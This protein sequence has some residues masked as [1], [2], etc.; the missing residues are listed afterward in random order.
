MPTD[1]EILE[2]FDPSTRRV[3][4]QLKERSPERYQER[5]DA[6]RAS[7][8]PAAPA[9]A[10]QAPPAPPTPPSAPQTPSTVSV[11]EVA[12]TPVDVAVAPTEADVASP[13]LTSGPSASVGGPD[14]AEREKNIREAAEAAVEYATKAP[15]ADV[16]FLGAGASE[17]GKFQDQWLID[18]DK[19]RRSL[20]L[21]K[22]EAWRKDYE[23]EKGKPASP[24]EQLKAIEE[25]DAEVAKDLESWTNRLRGQGMGTMDIDPR[26]DLAEIR[27]SAAE[28]FLGR[29]TAPLEAMWRG[30]SID[31]AEGVTAPGEKL[32]EHI[33]YNEGWSNAGWTEWGEG[34][35]RQSLGTLVSTALVASG[36]EDLSTEVYGATPLAAITLGGKLGAAALGVGDR[37]SAI[38]EWGSD[39]HIS[40]L[41][42]GHD[43]F[44]SMDMGLNL[45]IPRDGATDQFLSTV[46][47]AMGLDLRASDIINFGYNLA[48]ALADVDLFTAA[49]AATGG[50]SYVAGKAGKLA[51][52][53]AKA[54]KLGDT[55]IEVLDPDL[56]RLYRASSAENVLNSAISAAQEAKKAG[57][58]SDDMI[59][60]AND[61]LYAA[62][63]AEEIS[64]AKANAIFG[65]VVSRMDAELMQSKAPEA[66]VRDA[67]TRGKA[68]LDRLDDLYGMARSEEVLADEAYRSG[69]SLDLVKQSYNNAR[70]S[71]QE[72][73]QVLAAHAAWEEAVTK[74]KEGRPRMRL[75]YARKQ[76]LATL[77][78]AQAKL[79]ALRSADEATAALSRATAE[80]HR[81]RGHIKTVEGALSK[82]AIT[83][84]NQ[85]TLRDMA[86]NHVTHIKYLALADE[87]QKGIDS[88]EAVQRG[89][90]STKRAAGK[91]L[92][93]D[94]AAAQRAADAVEAKTADIIKL[95][96]DLLDMRSDAT[97]DIGEAVADK[98][99]ELAK[100]WDEWQDAVQDAA[101]YGLEKRLQ[102]L[103]AAKGQ[104]LADAGVIASEQKRLLGVAKKSKNLRRTAEQV[105]QR[106]QREVARIS[107]LIN[108][109]ADKRMSRNRALTE[110]RFMQAMTELRDQFGRIATGTSSLEDA[111]A[112]TLER[113]FLENRAVFE[114]GLLA[115]AKDKAGS[116]YNTIIEPWRNRHNFTHNK[117]VSDMLNDMRGMHARATEELI[118]VVQVMGDGNAGRAMETYLTSTEPLPLPGGG[119]TLYNTTGREA[120]IEGVAR[121]LSPWEEAQD[122]LLSQ[123]AQLEAA[124]K[125]TDKDMA[126]LDR[127]PKFVSALAM[128]FVGPR[129][130]VTARQSVG[131]L[132]K[133]ASYA[134]RESKG[135]I[136]KF[137]KLHQ[138]STTAVL[139]TAGVSAR[140]LESV[141]GIGAWDILT[142]AVIGASTMDR[143]AQRITEYTMKQIGNS[144]GMDMDAVG[145][146]LSNM[147]TNPG[148]VGPGFEDA[149]KIFEIMGMRPDILRHYNALSETTKTGIEAISNGRGYNV[150]IPR[151]IM[152]AI[153]DAAGNIVKSTDYF[154]QQDAALDLIAVRRWMRNVSRL[155]SSHLVYG[156][157]AVK[158]QAFTNISV[159][160]T[161]QAWAYEGAGTALGAQARSLS[162]TPAVSARL[163]QYL[164]A[165]MDFLPGNIGRALDARRAKMAQ[166]LGKPISEVRPSPFVAENPYVS[167]I[168]DPLLLPNDAIVRQ[169][170]PVKRTPALTAGQLRKIIVEQGVA[171]T[172]ITKSSLRQVIMQKQ[173]VK[174][175]AWNR[176]A[177]AMEYLNVPRK[178]WIE[179]ADTFEQRQRVAL[180]LELFVNK[181]M[182]PELAAKKTKASYYDWNSP[183]SYV[184]DEY[185]SQFFMFW[186]YHRRSFDQAGQVLASQLGFGDYAGE[187]AFRANTFLSAATGGTPA[188]QARIRDAM[189]FERA[190]KTWLRSD[191]SEDSEEER[192]SRVYPGWAEGKGSKTFLN[193]EKLSE[194]F[195][196]KY[197]DYTGNDVTHIAYT[198]PGHPVLEKLVTLGTLLRAVAAAPF[199]DERGPGVG[200]A[201]ANVAFEFGGSFTKPM[202]QAWAYEAGLAR[203]PRYYGEHDWQVRRAG[204]K[205]MI[206]AI[207]SVWHR[208][209]G[210][211]LSGVNIDDKTGIVKL[212][213]GARRAYNLAA[214]ITKD[215]ATYLE[216]YQQQKMMDQGTARSIL[217]TLNQFFG[218]YRGYLNNPEVSL[219]FDERELGNLL[220]EQKRLTKGR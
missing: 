197:K 205:Q 103:R 130:V 32:P 25:I 191:D 11:P 163:G 158:P 47:A 139:G 93:V 198:A 192:L 62:V 14:N 44:S 13:S 45:G 112:I 208:L 177:K 211:D 175:S 200:E 30:A 18:V 22:I 115:T 151:Q 188:A 169:A 125:G 141:G 107:N 19:K 88:I 2:S 49:G 193:Q 155:I 154:V 186:A 89:M 96:N 143:S 27:E 85:L 17:S 129:D 105:S 220:D 152:K 29:A 90:S 37:R 102:S 71:V 176:V 109:P 95:R 60:A 6:K 87:L 83:P 201:L 46:P 170:D 132:I 12:T 80:T 213:P 38:L 212:T 156:L 218:T 160:N 146:A 16:G 53:V 172:F 147:A 140:G 127:A 149:L 214:P 113:M 145:K 182:D 131:R 70:K 4:L 5:L 48:L 59:R 185:I 34:T 173:G 28:S 134:L 111:Q 171:S 56:A 101:K 68:D 51:A 120:L 69:A 66:L 50:T 123:F 73:E 84:R 142:K 57:G 159:G 92:F 157:I 35:L 79:I 219:E 203:R 98:Q 43:Q 133:S 116:V 108:A 168:M 209:A 124:A 42:K 99:K 165:S 86:S 174:G 21:A 8:S 41:A 76:A 52:P 97:G 178:T 20:R 194:D 190:M 199:G 217:F 204:D 40:L 137:M 164:P 77:P 39:E 189:Q 180:F 78:E 72:N 196:K 195:A 75:D 91:G 63:D 119:V 148:N 82:R 179:M 94:P 100:A 150:F 216:Y 110:K 118:G 206:T 61:A 121:T 162:P 183:M 136:N 153:E 1:K 128:M 81:L 64:P 184:E 187:G 161:Y 135:D 138:A 202:M 55:A 167:E 7:L 122:V 67:T 26:G 144:R 33:T 117:D 23:K 9:P 31:F 104:L 106:Q 126:V 207:N 54:M 10:P 58:T 65:A 114:G 166:D 215:F 181:G 24:E 3:L 36:N 74:V 210:T 15:K